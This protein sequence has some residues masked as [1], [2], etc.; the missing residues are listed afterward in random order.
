MAGLRRSGLSDE[1]AQTIHPF[2]VDGF[3]PAAGQGVLAIQT[4]S[5]NAEI[6]EFLG[7][8]D[9]PPTHDALRA[10]RL[11]L[12]T[13]GVGCSSC[14]AVHVEQDQLL[15][16][17]SAMLAQPDGTDMLIVSAEA[18]SWQ[19]TGKALAKKLLHTE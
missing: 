8:L 5:N 16:R 6:V 13:L 4:A 14:I 9:D 17:G 2:E 19:A 18:N 12:R 7:K 3:I 10:E 11:V 15:W 1:F